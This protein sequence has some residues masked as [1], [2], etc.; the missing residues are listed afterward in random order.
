MEKNYILQDLIRKGVAV[1]C[2]NSEEVIKLGDWVE[3]LYPGEG[4]YVKKYKNNLSIKE[5]GGEIAIRIQQ[6]H[7]GID[8]G[9]DRP[10]YYK[11]MGFDVITFTELNCDFGTF[12]VDVDGIR[13]LL[14]CDIKA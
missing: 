10:S 14:F 12:D 1:V 2:H 4:I 11:R 3:A 8:C 6:W 7:N 5:F 13:E 9:W